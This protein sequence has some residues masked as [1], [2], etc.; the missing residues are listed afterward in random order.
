VN[1][2]FNSVRAMAGIEDSHENGRDDSFDPGR[3]TADIGGSHEN[4]RDESSS[5]DDLDEQQSENEVVL[6][7]IL[8]ITRMRY[9][10]IEARIG[11]LVEK[12]LNGDHVVSSA[13]LL[14]VGCPSCNRFIRLGRAAL[15]PSPRPSL[16]V[17]P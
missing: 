15:R 9:F 2:S 3:A 16:F 6:E 12:G 11:E 7:Q 8:A 10:K 14:S 13:I 5:H 1:D 17:S 4:V